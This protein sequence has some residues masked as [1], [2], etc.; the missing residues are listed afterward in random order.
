MESDQF[1]TPTN[2]W[3]PSAAKGDPRPEAVEEKHGG[4]KAATEGHLQ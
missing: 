3:P 2:A 1:H 4:Q